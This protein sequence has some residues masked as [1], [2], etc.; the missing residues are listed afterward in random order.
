MTAAPCLSL[1]NN[2]D[3]ALPGVLCVFLH[4]LFPSLPHLDGV[5]DIACIVHELKRALRQRLVPRAA[6]GLQWVGD[7]SGQ[8][9][10]EVGGLCTEDGRQKKKRGVGY[11]G[12]K[13]RQIE[14]QRTQKTREGGAE[15]EMC[16]E[17]RKRGW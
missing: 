16:T 8:A 14:T 2:V 5:H 17:N 4:S 13:V 11:D 9:I 1:H 15:I 12:N 10:E 6:A 7:A 3:T